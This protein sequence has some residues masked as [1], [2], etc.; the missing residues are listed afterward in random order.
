MKA[1]VRTNRTKAQLLEEN[2]NLRERIAELE[3]RAAVGADLAARAAADDSRAFLERVLDEMPAIIGILEG[4]QHICRYL[5]PF[6]LQLL[7]QGGIQPTGEPMERILP[8]LR[9]QGLIAVLDA[10]FEAGQPAAFPE[11][12]FVYEGP[13]G[14]RT[15]TWWDF[16]VAPWRGVSG[17]VAGVLVLGPEVTERVRQ[18]TERDRLDQQREEFLSIATHEL[19]TPLTSLK[20]RVQFARRQL[21]RHGAVE[22]ANLDWMERAIERLE[23]LVNDLVD[24]VRLEAGKLVV[25]R[26]RVELGQLCRGL[27]QDHAAISGRQIAERLPDEPIWVEADAMR[28]G[29]VLSNL[30]TNAIRYTPADQPVTV[31]LTADEAEARVSVRD[32][33]P[34]I[35]PDVLPHLFERFYRAPGAERQPGGEEGLGLGLY[36]A[37]EIVR[38]HGGRLWCES[39]A[40]TGSTFTFALPRVT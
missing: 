16:V 36:I 2:A 12:Y 33:G 34:G 10:V 30:L 32:R 22:P 37:Y 1:T 35:P 38:R 27:I 20:G 17:A 6:A 24:L 31:A 5:N 23:L 18:R 15:E 21:E 9:E 39:V 19:R 25:R 26:E 29:Q 14:E 28:L 13:D 3:R 8:G 40:G 4:P 7:T 11:T